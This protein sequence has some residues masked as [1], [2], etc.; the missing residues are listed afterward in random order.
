LLINL[1]GNPS[2][3]PVDDAGDAV[4][5]REISWRK[6]SVSRGT[7]E[8]GRAASMIRSDRA[9]R[10]LGVSPPGDRLSI[11]NGG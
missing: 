10:D 3:P 1:L 6:S 5:Y 9:E 2:M 8:T 11:L 7:A 4:L